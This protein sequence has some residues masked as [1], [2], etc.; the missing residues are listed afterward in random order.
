MCIF[1][2]WKKSVNMIS[3]LWASFPGLLTYLSYG[4]E[5]KEI[6]GHFTKTEGHWRLI[7]TKPW[8]WFPPD[9]GFHC[10]Y[11]VQNFAKFCSLN[12]R[13]IEFQINRCSSWFWELIMSVGPLFNIR[14]FESLKSS[15]L[16][17][18]LENDIISFLNFSTIITSESQLM[19]DIKAIY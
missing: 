17:F 5:M 7:K 10:Q 9:T 19:F 12:N 1:F 3:C 13:K 15:N 11:R 4:M 18:G 16:H 6:M 14:S 8:F 2:H